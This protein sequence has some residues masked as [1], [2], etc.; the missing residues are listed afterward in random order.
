MISSDDIFTTWLKMFTTS[1]SLVKKEQVTF[2]KKQKGLWGEKWTD[3]KTKFSKPEVDHSHKQSSR[4]GIALR[5]RDFQLATDGC[6]F[7]Q[8]GLLKTENK[9]VVDDLLDRENTKKS[10][11]DTG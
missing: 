10:R 11:D 4:V 3:L 2:V 6:E 7:L 5:N 9:P 1:I 8:R